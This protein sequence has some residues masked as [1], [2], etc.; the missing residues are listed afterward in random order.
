V[1]RLKIVDVEAP[2]AGKLNQWRLVL[3]PP[4]S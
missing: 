2:D 3:K 4:T 1:W